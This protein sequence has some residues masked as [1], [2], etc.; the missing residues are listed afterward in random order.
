MVSFQGWF[1]PIILFLI[2]IIVLSPKYFERLFIKIMGKIED[3]K[4]KLKR[5]K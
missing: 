5:L 3:K 4:N 1:V 2:L